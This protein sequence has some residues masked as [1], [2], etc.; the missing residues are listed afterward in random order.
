MPLIRIDVI[1]GRSR[2][3]SGKAAVLSLH[4]PDDPC[5]QCNERNGPAASF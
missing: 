2:S 3:R 1:K 5:G 4:E